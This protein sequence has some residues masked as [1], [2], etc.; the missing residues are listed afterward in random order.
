MKSISPLRYPGG[1]AKF[2]DN[3]IKIFENNKIEKPVYCEAFAGGAG[4]ALLLLKNNMVKKLILNDIDKSIFTFWKSVLCYTKDFCRMIENVTITLDEREIQKKLQ[5]DKN[6]L[7]MN[8]K[9][10]ILKLGFSTFFLNRVNRSGII[11]AGV[12]GG[13]NQDGN[14]KMDCRFNKTKLIERIK[15]IAKYKDKIE[16]YNLDATVFIEKIKNKKSLFIFFDPPYFNKGHELYTNFYNKID[17]IKLANYISTINK[18]W[19]ITY[20]NTSE[21]KEIYSKYKIKEFN[22]NYSLEKKRKA[23]EI[24]IVK[25][26]FII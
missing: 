23:K 13:I 1:K 14:Y 16:L 7:N 20:D 26:N 19:I 15:D 3:I 21:I 22:I 8:E 4:L 17:H 5:K 2:Y 11:N 12:I 18:N 25:N 6:N 24:L 9:E 10:D